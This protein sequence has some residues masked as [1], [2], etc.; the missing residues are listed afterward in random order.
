MSAAALYRCTAIYEVSLRLGVQSWKHVSTSHIRLVLPL[1]P[2]LQAELLQAAEEHAWP[3]RHLREEIETLHVAG[4]R[5]SAPRFRSRS[6]LRSALR[7]LHG[8]LDDVRRLLLVSGGD[9]VSADAL[10]RISELAVSVRDACTRLMDGLP[11]DGGGAS[12]PLAAGGSALEAA[13][14]PSHP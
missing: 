13:E 3:V 8:R 5:A 7:S 1:A 9:G 14:A 2:A 4:G 12:S 10:R 6:R 11:A